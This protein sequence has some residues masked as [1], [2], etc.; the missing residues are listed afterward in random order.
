MG[1]ECDYNYF[2]KTFS[3]MGD[4]HKKSIVKLDASMGLVAFILNIVWPGLGTIIAG[5]I[6]KDAMVNNLIVGILQM[7]LVCILVGWIWSI[8]TGYL[9]YN[10]SK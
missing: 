3:K 8:Y 9:I 7:V 1:E 5:F 10:A 2:N 4:M 6:N